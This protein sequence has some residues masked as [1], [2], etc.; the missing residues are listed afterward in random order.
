MNE[1][2]CLDTG[3]SVSLRI[4]PVPLKPYKVNVHCPACGVSFESL[5]AEGDVVEGEEA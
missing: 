5:R 1:T 3:E 2:T 4:T